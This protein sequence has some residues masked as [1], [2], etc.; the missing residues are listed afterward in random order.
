MISFRQ[1]KVYGTY[2]LWVLIIFF[3]VSCGGSGQQGGIT[4]VTPLPPGEP[5]V[6]YG[7]SLSEWEEATQANTGQSASSND[8][9]SGETQSVSPLADPAPVS[10]LAM[11]EV[12]AADIGVPFTLDNVVY[13]QILWDGLIP[14]DFTANAIMS[15]YEDQLAK[16][17]DGS[18]EAS[19]LYRKMQEEF[20]N[21]PVNEVLNETLVRL[22]GFIAPLEYTDNLITEFLLV[23]YFGACIHVPPPPANQTVLVQ[24]AEGEGIKPEDSYNPIWVM[25]KLTTEGTTTQ[26]AAAGY[27]IQE[28]IFEPYTNP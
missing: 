3:V 11:P 19:D 22:P 2:V 13:R 15:K 27:Y 5:S 16:L 1:T 6:A 10:P 23:P 8:G 25:G 20:N 26:L 12:T 4:K 24:A 7:A 18:P 14:V 21:A 28:A 9:R 17:E